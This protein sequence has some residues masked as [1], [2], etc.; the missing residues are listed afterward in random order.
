MGGLSVVYLYEFVGGVTGD[1]KAF[2]GTIEISLHLG[3]SLQDF[4]VMLDVYG[5]AL[6]REIR[7]LDGGCSA[8]SQQAELMA[9]LREMLG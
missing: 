1:D 5:S 7:R 4:A 2:F 8:V 6:H 9:A 3:I